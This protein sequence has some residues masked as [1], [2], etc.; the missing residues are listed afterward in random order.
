M[1]GVIATNAGELNV[2]QLGANVYI[3]NDRAVLRASAAGVG[4][5]PKT[6]VEVGVG[7]VEAE[8]EKILKQ[9]NKIKG[10]KQR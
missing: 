8:V 7:V 5:D 3:L 10:A 6:A 4:F 1:V 9:L 2:F